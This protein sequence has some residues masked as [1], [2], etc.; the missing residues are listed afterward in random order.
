MGGGMFELLDGVATHSTACRPTCT[1]QKEDKGTLKQ[2]GEG[3][4]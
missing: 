1:S 3:L 4:P 2:P